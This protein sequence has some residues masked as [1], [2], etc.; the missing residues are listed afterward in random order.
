[1]VAAPRR[2]A[3]DEALYFA[4]RLQESS[5]TV[6]ALVVNRLHPRYDPAPAVLTAPGAVD[7]A[8]QDPKTAA[9][10]TL[11][12]NL[13]DLQEIAER[14]EQYF[15]SL[16]RRVAPAPVFRAPMLTGDVHDIDGLTTLGRYL[17]AEPSAV[18]AQV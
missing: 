18:S 6:E 15:D 14:E 10:A 11:L 17:F 13:H 1:L 4:R 7:T 3:V 5:I 2:D 8:L 16:V 9:L 12:A